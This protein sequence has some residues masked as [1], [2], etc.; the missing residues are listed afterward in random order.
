VAEF[1][2]V[3]EV[4]QGEFGKKLQAHIEFLSQDAG[5]VFFHV[6]PSRKNA[7]I[8]VVVS[9]WKTAADAE[10]YVEVSGLLTLTE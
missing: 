1:F 5:A 4:K 7:A 10:A 8:V 3:P 6:A 9:G 2:S